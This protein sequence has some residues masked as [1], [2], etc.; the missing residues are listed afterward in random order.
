MKTITVELTELEAEKVHA[1]IMRI[2]QDFVL[3]CYVAKIDTDGSD[4]EARRYRF[5]RELAKKFE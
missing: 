2:A 5:Y 1:C 4:E 3:E